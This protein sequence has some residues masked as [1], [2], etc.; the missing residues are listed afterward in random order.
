MSYSE[1]TTI[2]KVRT[3]FNL[4]IN[5]K[6]VLFADVEPIEPSDYLKTTLTEYIPPCQR[7]QYGKSAIGVDYCSCI[8]RSTAHLKLPNRLF[9]RH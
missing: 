4:T 3:A 8:A 5:E 7:Y 6:T 1:F 9:F 2:A